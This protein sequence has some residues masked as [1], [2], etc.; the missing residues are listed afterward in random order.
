MLVQVAMVLVFLIRQRST[1]AA[2][3]LTASFHILFKNK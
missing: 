3:N 1:K 2:Q